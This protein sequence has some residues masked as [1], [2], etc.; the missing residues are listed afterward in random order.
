VLARD[1]SSSCDAR[2]PARACRAADSRGFSCRLHRLAATVGRGFLGFPH[3]STSQF[4][5]GRMFGAPQNTCTV[6]QA[7]PYMNL[8]GL[9]T[10]GRP[11]I[12]E[13]ICGESPCQ[14]APLTDLRARAACS[15]DALE[16]HADGTYGRMV[17]PPLKPHRTMWGLR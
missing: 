8:E 7:L 12:V 2:V 11:Q 10:F 14:D 17:V 6:T 5:V 1:G 3:K 9:R 16:P 15:I 13:W 4:G